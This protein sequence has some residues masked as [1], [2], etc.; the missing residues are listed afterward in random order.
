[1]CDF[2]LHIFS[3]KWPG[4]IF[5]SFIELARVSQA[6][7]A[8]PMRKIAVAFKNFGNADD[9]VRRYREI[10]ASRSDCDLRDFEDAGGLENQLGEIFASWFDSVQNRP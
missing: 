1:M 4:A 8:R 7:P 5:E 10:L 3:A 6:D 9:N 2:F